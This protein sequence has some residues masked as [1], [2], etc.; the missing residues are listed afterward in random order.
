MDPDSICPV[1]SGQYQTGSETLL[2]YAY[3]LKLTKLTLH[4][5]DNPSGWRTNWSRCRTCVQTAL[6]QLILCVNPAFVMILYLKSVDTVK[7]I[8]LMAYLHKGVSL[9]QRRFRLCYLFSLFC[10]HMHMF[11][12]P[13]IW[14]D[15]VDCKYALSD[16]C[17]HIVYHVSTRQDS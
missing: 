5:G 15:K 14:F 12:F 17:K 1:G 9:N 13:I 10:L 8:K 2:T 16:S 6:K 4:N 7:H 3:E 11:I